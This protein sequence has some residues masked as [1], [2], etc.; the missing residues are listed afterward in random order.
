MRARRQA[1][2]WPRAGVSYGYPAL[3]VQEFDGRASEAHVDRRDE[4]RELG[5][6]ILLEHGVLPEAVAEEQRLGVEPGPAGPGVQ[7]ASRQRDR[8]TARAEARGP[9]VGELVAQRHLAQLGIAGVVE[10]P[11]D[12]RTG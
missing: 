6:L 2:A 1:A 7:V 3:S 8:G 5:Q 12:E 11:I 4:L 9:F 10:D